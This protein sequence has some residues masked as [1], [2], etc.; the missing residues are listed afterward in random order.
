MGREE[1]TR[2]KGKG[3]GEEGG[4][5]LAQRVIHLWNRFKLTPVSM[6]SLCRFKA[7]LRNA[8]LSRFLHYF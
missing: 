8:D 2:G 4:K 7:L 1:R 6:T 5:F 3:G